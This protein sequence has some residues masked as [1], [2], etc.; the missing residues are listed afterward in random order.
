MQKIGSGKGVIGFK[1]QV[2]IGTSAE[3][4]L[5]PAAVKDG[6]LDTRVFLKIRIP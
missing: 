5:G 6:L 1:R 2:N 3:I 4:P